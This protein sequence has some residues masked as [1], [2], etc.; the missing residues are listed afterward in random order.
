MKT[1]RTKTATE[2]LS[3]CLYQGKVTSMEAF[4]FPDHYYIHT[5]TNKIDDFRFRKLEI[6]KSR[7]FLVV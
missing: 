2:I 7:V 6:W 3:L 1:Y 5:L 4:G